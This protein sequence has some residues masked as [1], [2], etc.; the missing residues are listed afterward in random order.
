MSSHVCT[1]YRRLARRRG[2]YKALVAAA[3]S[4]LVIIYHMLRNYKP[5]QDLRADYFEHLDAQRGQ[6]DHVR[7]LEPLGSSVTL[8]LLSLA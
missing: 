1:Q 8:A 5:S 4:L 7:Q 6:R 3:Y 2:P